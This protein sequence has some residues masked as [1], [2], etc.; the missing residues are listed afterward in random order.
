MH[1][2][3]PPP[4]LIQGSVSDETGE[5]KALVFTVIIPGARLQ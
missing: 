4:F 5:K 3:H 2:A 1:Q